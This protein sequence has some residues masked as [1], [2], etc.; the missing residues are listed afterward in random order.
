MD[1]I[2]DTYAIRDQR[3]Y[4]SEDQIVLGGKVVQRDSR[5]VEI[6]STVRTFLRTN[7]Q[8]VRIVQVRA[9]LAMVLRVAQ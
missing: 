7:V 6:S 1:A 8:D 2:Y 9:A 3:Q 5:L 4:F